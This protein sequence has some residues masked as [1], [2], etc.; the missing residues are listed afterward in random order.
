MIGMRL[1]RKKIV[2]LNQHLSLLNIS[3]SKSSVPSY[4]CHYN[5]DIYIR[6]GREQCRDYIAFV[7]I[8]FN[9][10]VVFS[11]MPL[12]ASFFICGCR[13]SRYSFFNFFFS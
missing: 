3:S 13:K 4:I 7:I 9:I 12:P 2:S 11:F 1:R 6:E 10:V 8:Y 5:E